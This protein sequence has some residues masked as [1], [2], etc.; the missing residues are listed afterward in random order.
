M[1]TEDYVSFETAKLLKEKGFEYNPDES[2]WLIDANNKMY[3][4]SCI[5]AYDYVDVPTES[6]QRPKNGY[7]L[8]TQAM[9]M[10][11][12]REVHKL[13]IIL[14]IH[15]L[16][17]ANQNGWMYTISRILENGNEYVDS[18]GDE[19]DKNFYPTYEEA[20]EA[21]IKYCLENLI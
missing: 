17:F 3:W 7:R 16:Y 2:Y 6:F 9:T 11:W 14:D 20:C 19:N 18:K 12:L 1:M 15:W 10:K 4:I 5:G 21:A 13:H 8:V